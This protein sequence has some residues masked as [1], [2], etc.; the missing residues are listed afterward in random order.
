M[1]SA[2][3]GC[4]WTCSTGRPAQRFSPGPLGCSTHRCQ[5]VCCKEAHAMPT[6]QSFLPKSHISLDCHVFT[7]CVPAPLGIPLC[8][9]FMSWKS[10]PRL[11]GTSWVL[12]ICMLM[13]SLKMS[14][15][16]DLLPSPSASLLG[17]HP[18]NACSSFFS[19]G[20]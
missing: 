10:F 7:E 8:F 2:I 3:S 14:T 19:G 20:S 5:P 12:I 4:S 15:A 6:A 11:S 9:V 16:S 17:K 13:L 1:T 18:C